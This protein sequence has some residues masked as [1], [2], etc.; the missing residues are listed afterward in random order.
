VQQ[1][2][3][4][5][6]FWAKQG[7]DKVAVIVACALDGKIKKVEFIYCSLAV[8]GYLYTAFVK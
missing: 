4:K 1:I 7:N 8:Y 5:A 6:A 2:H 3:L